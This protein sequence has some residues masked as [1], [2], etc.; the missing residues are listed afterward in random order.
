MPNRAQRRAAARQAAEKLAADA[1]LNNSRSTEEPMDQ[2]S[3]QTNEHTGEP[4]SEAKLNANRANAQK[5][6]GPRTSTGKSISSMNAVKTGLTGQTV[7]LPADDA[8]A[9]QQHID[10]HFT[11]YSPLSEQEQELTQSIAD[12]A[13]RLLRIPPLLA[14]L[15]AVGREEFADQVAHEPDLEKREALLTGKI[16]QAYRRDFNNINLQ[17]RRLRKHHQED[18]AELRSL[19]QERQRLAIEYALQR[20][21]EF[22]RALKIGNNCIRQKV[23]FNPAEFGF[24]FTLAEYRHYFERNDAQHKLTE[25]DLD[26]DTVVNA[27]RAA[28]KQQNI[29]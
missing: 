15:S 10:R 2:Q 11:R 28:Q 7:L 27:Y 23:P 19:Q 14:S 12:T 26:F 16:Y 20:K 13:W 21:D 24:D 25:K 17:E 5:S 3:D 6:T 29:A 4:I 1:S 22:N 8:V 9:Y 18:I